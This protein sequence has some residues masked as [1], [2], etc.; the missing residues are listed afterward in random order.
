L[1]NK[2]SW[3]EKIGKQVEK[4]IE[5][6]RQKDLEEPISQADFD[7]IKYLLKSEKIP[8]KRISWVVGLEDFESTLLDG[9]DLYV[10]RIVL[11]RFTDICVKGGPELEAMPPDIV[12]KA[13]QYFSYAPKAHRI[14]GW[15]S[16]FGTK[17]FPGQEVLLQLSGDLPMQWAFSDKL[18]FMIKSEDLEVN[19]FSKVKM[20]M[21]D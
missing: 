2:A 15:P 9:K 7:E 5:R 16:H 19:D 3:A 21:H 14:G 11:E 20:L 10:E 17:A 1:C 18:Y 12:A 6:L 13:E 4:Q 8:M